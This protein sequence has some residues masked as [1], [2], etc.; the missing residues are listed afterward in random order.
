MT[1]VSE[2]G[3]FSLFKSEEGVAVTELVKPFTQLHEI[4]A[5]TIT[6]YV[7]R[8]FLRA[9]RRLNNYII[10]LS[11]YFITTNSGCNS[12]ARGK[13]ALWQIGLKVVIDLL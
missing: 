7:T 13:I 9:V 2:T 10:E 12:I 3:L 8:N 6:I 1:F 11:H 5:R 4:D